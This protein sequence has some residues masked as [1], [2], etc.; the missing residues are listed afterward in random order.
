M[1]RRSDFLTGRCAP[2]PD[3]RPRVINVIAR[4]FDV[5]RCFEDPTVQLGNREIAGRCGL[6]RSTVSRL[7]L[8][9]TRIGELAYLPDRQKYRL[10]IRSLVGN[11]RETSRDGNSLPSAPLLA[12]SS[13]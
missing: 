4:A 8:T 3:T 11:A 6:P 13:E 9:L 7:T 2:G 10:G 5:L 1:G 12:S